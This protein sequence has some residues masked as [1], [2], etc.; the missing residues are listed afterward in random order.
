MGFLSKP[1]STEI[2]LFWSYLKHFLSAGLPLVLVFHHLMKVLSG[3]PWPSLLNR[4]ERNLLRGQKLSS[5]L[6]EEKHIFSNDVI[7]MIK[8]AE[9]KGNYPEII[10][11]IIDYQK[12]QLNTRQ[13]L[14][15]ALRYPLILLGIMGLLLYV[16]LNQIIPQLQTYLVSLGLK[17]LPMATKILIRTSEVFPY[18]LVF[19]A[20]AGGAIL[21]IFKAKGAW[22]IKYRHFFE[23]YIRWVPGVGR[24]Y[25]KLAIITFIRVLATLLNSGVELLVS[26]HQSIKVVSNSWRAEQLTR[27]K[28]RLIQGEKLSSALKDVLKHYPA[29]GL[30]FDL[31][32]QTG[33][34]PS[35]LT[36]Y[37]EFE[38]MQ[39]K[40][41]V[42]QY[43]QNLQPLMIMIMGSLLTWVV[44]S[45]LL[46]MYGQIE[47]LGG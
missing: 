9:Q 15:N 29:L 21:L 10:E 35:I 47:G 30:L 4:I 14:R 16:V 19:L 8:I 31:G 17:D 22:S 6:A 42:D 43:V 26:L 28:D 7:E 5:S 38:M 18:V 34:L 23:K 24:L 44:I 45:I 36:E 2:I 32:E 39:F 41:E 27:G 25:D 37:V 3:N 33:R 12:W 11:M 13:T 20:S 1:K 46:P 40:V